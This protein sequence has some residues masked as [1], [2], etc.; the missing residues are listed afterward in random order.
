MN[1]V[2]S[3]IRRQLDLLYNPPQP[4]PPTLKTETVV[5]RVPYFGLPSQTYG[6]RLS[7]MISKQYP[8]K[9]I[10]IVY[11]VKDRIGTGFTTK[12]KIP[13]LIKSGVVYQAQCSQCNQSY[14][15]KTYRH[16]KTRINEHLSEQTKSLPPTGHTTHPVLKRNKPSTQ[17]FTPA[18]T[19]MTRSRTG[20]LPKPLHD[21]T[22]DYL[23][24]YLKD[25]FQ[26]VVLVD[27]KGETTTPKSSIA[28]HYY[29]TGHKFISD[30]FKI[31]TTEQ[32][33]YRLL[34]KESILIRKQNPVLNNTDRSVPLY[35]Y[36]NGVNPMTTKTENLRLVIGTPHT[37]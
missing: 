8:L 17:P 10:R 1:Y 27:K 20:K 34:V 36:P 25:L 5:M 32:H 22:K 3:I 31:L 16:L 37:Q 2:D 4:I 35:V 14:I 13:T 12:D 18:K 15:G 26:N 6:K 33:R 19:H 23:Q 11:D 24:D 30:D 28:K 7:A 9:Q 29:A 21:L